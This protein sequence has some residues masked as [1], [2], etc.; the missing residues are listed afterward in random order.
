MNSA[1]AVYAA[2][3]GEQRSHPSRAPARRD[4]RKSLRMAREINLNGDMGESFGRYSIGDDEALIELVKSAS[5]AC[6]F[7]AGDPSVMARSV[8]LAKAHGVSVGAH[9]SFPDLQGFGRRAMRMRAA[10]IEPMVA[11]QIG[12]LQAIAAA[13][14]VQV[15]HVKPH[16]ALNNIAHDDADCARAIARAIKAVDRNLIFVANALSQMV[17]A[18]EAEGLR[19]A[20]EAYADRTYDDEGRLTSRQVEG[21]LITDPAKAVDQVLA[22]MDNNAL[23]AASGR[24]LSTRI[25]TICAHGDEA[26]GVA[27]MRAVRQALE[28]RGVTIVTLPEM[29]L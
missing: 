25:D 26:T 15:S 16:G 4:V 28:A 10:E 13:Q 7:H 6:G 11:Y 3:T 12:A 22:F 21:A 5:I 1:A 9:P 8:A 27:V 17:R 14:G 29:I 24:K 2:S 20:H 23:V 18:G 19:V